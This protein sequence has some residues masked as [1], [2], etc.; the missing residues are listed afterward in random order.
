MAAQ[1]SAS[2]GPRGQEVT[3]KKS[4]ERK[5]RPEE[6]RSFLGG[7][8]RRRRRVAAPRRGQLHP[9]QRLAAKDDS[10]LGPPS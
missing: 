2:S 7:G 3:A 8:P 4:T 1:N 5:V 6:H 9:R 10:W